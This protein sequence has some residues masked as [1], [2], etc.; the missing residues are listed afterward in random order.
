MSAAVPA[1]HAVTP[2]P[3][4]QPALVARAAR[5]D[6]AAPAV[7]AIAV[8]AGLAVG[9]LTSFGQTLLGGTWFAGLANAVSPWLVASFLVGALARR[10]WVAALA[11][12]VACAG[13]VA[14]YYLAADLR[15]FAV[16]TSSVA[17]WAVSGVVG[18]PV[19]GWAGR[20]WRTAAGRWR[21]L[22]PALLVGCWLAEAVVTYAVVLRYG[23]DAVVF[24]AVS[25]V[26]VVLLGR[27]GGQTGALL[28][29]L[30][31]AAVVGAAGFAAVHLALA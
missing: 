17:V 23:D 25:A 27:P 16:G 12:L 9:A 24:A 5:P 26:L 20:L 28:R 2:A 11:G 8:G 15:G 3:P 6:L 31:A 18:G 22:G 1:P 10:G 21:G 7:L 13:E 29:W 14:G 19:F 30:P 4:G